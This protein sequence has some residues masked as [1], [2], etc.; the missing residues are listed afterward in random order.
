LQ[1]IDAKLGNDNFVN[2]APAAVVEKE[3]SRQLGL[4]QEI[5]QLETQAARLQELA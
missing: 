5:E 3:R 4:R 2:K 1:K